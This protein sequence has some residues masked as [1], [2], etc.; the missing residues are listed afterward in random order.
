MIGVEVTRVDVEM[1]AALELCAIGELGQ[2][3]INE[4]I[5]GAGE[6]GS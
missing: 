6:T 1:G 5:A 3:P 4:G 2:F